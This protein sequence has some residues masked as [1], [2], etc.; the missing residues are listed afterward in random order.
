MTAPYTVEDLDWLKDVIG[1]PGRLELDP[2]G[3][4]IVTPTTDEHELA[5]GHMH[6]QS[7]EQLGLPPEC[8]LTGI[9]WRVPGGSGY[10]NR[11]DLIVL[12]RGWQRV[13]DWHLDPP[14]LL[15][16][17]VASRS[18]VG[19][20]RGRK[21]DDYRLGGT[22]L[23]VRVDFYDPGRAGFELYDFATGD[24]TVST[25]AVDLVVGGRPLRFDL[26]DLPAG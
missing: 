25:T 2:W 24:I 10:Y 26:S 22:G 13:G 23:Y 6:A 16:V 15:V 18:T 3:N 21:R 4:L 19:I 14:P 7:R 8:I 17:E 12:A 5:I 20:D 1:V 9:T 11:P